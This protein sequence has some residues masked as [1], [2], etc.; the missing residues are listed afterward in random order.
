MIAMYDAAV[1]PSPQVSWK[2]II[3]EKPFLF[4][5]LLELL[6]FWRPVFFGELFYFRDLSMHFLPARELAADYI[7]NFEL[8]L[9]DPYRQG[10]KPLLANPNNMALYPSTLLYALLPAGAA[11]TIDII[12]HH[13]VSM[14]GMYVFARV[15]SL[16]GVA[17]FIAAI[18][19][20]YAGYSLSLM[21]LLNWHVAWAY[22]PLLLSS[23]HLYATRAKRGW[24]IL[25]VLLASLQLLAGAPELFLFSMLTL[26]GLALFFGY[27]HSRKKAVALCV[28]LMVLSLAIAAV[29][30]LP[31]AENA[32]LTIRGVGFSF[33]SASRW[34]LH[35]YRILEFFFHE[36]TGHSNSA[37]PSFW[38]QALEGQRP[39]LL[40][41][42]FGLTP[43]VLALCTVV[44]RPAF[45]Q[46]RKTFYLF[47][48]LLMMTG[49]LLA[50]GRYLPG[51]WS[52]FDFFSWRSAFRFPVK[53]LGLAVLPLSLLA[54]AGAENIFSQKQNR[55]IL[56]CFWLVEIA[57]MALLL[58]T[59]SLGPEISQALFERQE[60]R[61][62]QGLTVGV[63][64]TLLVWTLI[65]FCIS[66]QHRRRILPLVAFIIVLDLAIAGQNVNFYA[67]KDFYARTPNLVHLVKKET[68]GG[69]LYRPG[70]TYRLGKPPTDEYYWHPLVQQELLLQASASRYGI[71]VIF[72]EELDG[73]SL[74]ELNYIT[75]VL[76][77]LGWEQRIPVLRA[78]GVSAILTDEYFSH[79]DVILKNRMANPYGRELF[80][81][82]IQEIGSPAFMPHALRADTA[83]EGL[84][85][86][87]RPE[88]DARNQAIVANVSPHQG[89]CAGLKVLQSR[90]KRQGRYDQIEILCGGYVVFPEPL[91]PGWRVSINGKN[92]VPVKTNII[93][94]S[95][96][97]QPGRY[98][99][100]KKYFPGSVAAGA[101]LGIAAMIGLVML[102]KVKRI[103]LLDFNGSQNGR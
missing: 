100:E 10:G 68:R 15:L 49:L 20:A 44:S 32:R 64:Q 6:Y 16:S 74:V 58:V 5:I 11:L 12:A 23:W 33:D 13:L 19:Y 14:L 57:L 92:V 76:E 17:S 72:H 71:R 36:F 78:T 43:I 53:L 50:L 60:S 41:V 26:L 30:I 75:L 28:L 80:L 8:P 82:S 4:L 77:G 47:L 25:C 39:F 65:C 7:V 18:I 96:Y 83:R 29:Q 9:W 67:P 62:Q 90:A 38:G 84:T 101:L 103:R 54:A 46:K 93:L 61:I 97:L 51:L 94:S 2:Q 73:S 34:S 27:A 69:K 87:I 86:M 21:S 48:L 24:W 89:K 70:S 31:A 85:F 66:I 81:Y 52:L 63:F 35:P 37:S 45:F 56:V 88:F 95:I 102:V 99:M 40:S 55:R 42:Y 3:K 98:E 1:I 91:Y 22:L 79:K 59:L